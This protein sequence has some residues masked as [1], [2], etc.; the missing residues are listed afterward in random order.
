MTKPN[1][2]PYLSDDDPTRDLAA[3]WNRPYVEHLDGVPWHEAP[4]PRRWHRCRAQTT[5]WDRGRR[6][7]R[8][9]C[10]AYG[11]GFPPR[12]TDRNSSADDLIESMKTLAARL[13]GLRPAAR[14]PRWWRR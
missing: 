6:V 11:L 9:A 13:L 8:C 5:A 12:W 10:G 3:I 1:G 14:R 4:I 2:R 7:L